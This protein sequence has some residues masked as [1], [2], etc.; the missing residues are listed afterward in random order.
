MFRSTTDNL[1]LRV[2]QWLRQGISPRSLA[3]TLALGFVIG[4]IPILG[5]ATPACIALAWAL[6]L[7][8]PAIQAANYAASPVQGP[9]IFLFFRLG[10]TLVLPLVHWTLLLTLASH[11][12]LPNSIAQ[13]MMLPC[14]ALLGWF[15]VAGPAVAAI[16]LVL[17]PLLRKIAEHSTPS[18]TET[19]FS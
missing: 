14:E 19:A 16:T 5:A 8:H 9:F 4:C 3:F 12:P 17:T 15:I 11:G 10:S 13:L 7:N 1:R 6:R 18:V 2:R